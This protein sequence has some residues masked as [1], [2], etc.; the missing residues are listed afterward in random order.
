MCYEIRGGRKSDED[1]PNDT[2]KVVEIPNCGHAVNQENLLPVNTAL[3]QF[4]TRLKPSPLLHTNRAFKNV[5]SDKN[6]GLLMH[7]A[8]HSCHSE[9][10][11]VFEIFVE[12]LNLG[13]L[14]PCLFNCIVV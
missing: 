10:H 8:L 5:I 14:L 9:Y 6:N 12:C 3:R 4:L 1:S 7:S 2:T 13:F 11:G